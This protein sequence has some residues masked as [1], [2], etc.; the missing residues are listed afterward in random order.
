[1]VRF[2]HNTLTYYV[3]ILHLFYALILHSPRFFDQGQ[4]FCHSS[5]TFSSERRTKPQ[6]EFANIEEA[7]MRKLMIDVTR[8]L[9]FGAVLLALPAMM[10]SDTAFSSEK[11]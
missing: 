9:L 8:F 5:L 10:L 1:M 7:A 6:L 2:S 4:R 3:D 11:G